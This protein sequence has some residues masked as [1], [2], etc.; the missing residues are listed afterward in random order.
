L[1]N[2][3]SDL[4]T[5]LFMANCKRT[6][7]AIII[8]VFSVSTLILA[9]GNKIERTETVDTLDIVKVWAGHPVGFN[10]ITHAPY[11]FVSYYDDKRQLTVSQRLLSGRTWTHNKLPVTTGWDSHNY[12]TVAIDDD[13]YLHLSGDMHVTQLKYFRTTTPLNASTFQ[14]LDRMIGTEEARTTY[15]KFLRGAQNE[16]IFNYRD[17]SSGNGNEVYNIYDLKTKTWKRLLDRPLTDGEGKR[18]AYFDGP[19]KGPDGY[20]HLAWVWRDTP[21]AATNHDLSYARSKDLINWR[22]GAGN[23]SL[24]LPIKLKDCDIVDPVPPKGGMI[25]GNAKVGFDNQ[26]RVT[27]SYHKHDAQ[28]NTQPWTARLENGQWKKYQITDWPWHWD[29]GGF[30]T[31]KFSIN[32]GAVTKEDDGR[33]TQG[34]GHT[35]FGSGTWIIDPQT[36]DAIGKLQRQTTPPEMGRIEGTFPGLRVKTSGDAGKTDKTGIRYMLRWETLESNNDKPRP[37]PLPSPSMLRLYA[38]K[39]VIEDAPSGR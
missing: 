6:F 8:F 31:L 28:N 10:L 17:G 39:T 21:D 23:K 22:T 12:I 11:Q 5:F 13:G 37:E 20:F 9:Q 30:G 15:P 32:M 1:K 27:I 36:L 7:F 3:I 4:R 33:L 34:Y 16:L 25:N 29:F 24:I 2:K 19:I 35:K 26:G 18:N 14:R 38:V